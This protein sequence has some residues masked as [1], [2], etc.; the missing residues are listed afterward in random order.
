MEIQHFHNVR[1]LLR[2]LIDLHS[3]LRKYKRLYITFNIQHFIFV[4]HDKKVISYTNI[5]KN[6]LTRATTVQSNTRELVQSTAHTESK[7]RE[8]FNLDLKT[9]RVPL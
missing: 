3:K 1:I 6:K 5:G 8:D 7:N 2:F 4:N 9:F